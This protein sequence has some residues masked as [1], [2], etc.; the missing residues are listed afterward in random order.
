M[1]GADQERADF[2]KALFDILI[3]YHS[4]TMDMGCQ[5]GRHAVTMCIPECTLMKDAATFFYSMI[6]MYRTSNFPKDRVMLFDADS[7][8]IWYDEIYQ[9]LK[10]GIII[11]EG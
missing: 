1:I 7:I 9:C 3:R 11:Y 8:K 6:C 5:R 4:Q 10:V 2:K